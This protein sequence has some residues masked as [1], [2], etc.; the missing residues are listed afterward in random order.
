MSSSHSGE[1]KSSSGGTA[2]AFSVSSY[3][4]AVLANPLTVRATVLRK[5][6][7]FPVAAAEL[8][9]ENDILF[10]VLANPLHYPSTV[11][12][13][14]DDGN[15]VKSPS[16]RRGWTDPLA[17]HGVGSILSLPSTIGKH[18]VGEPF[19]AFLSFHNAATYA[20]G[21]V[22]FRIDCLHPTQQ[23]TSLVSYDCQRLEGKGNV[24][25]K[26]ELTLTDSGQHTL[27]VAV[28]FIDIVQEAKRLTWSSSFQVERAVTEVHRTLCAIPLLTRY[29]RNTANPLRTAGPTLEEV[30]SNIA[31]PTRKYALS[32]CLQNTSSLPLAIVDVALHAGDAFDVLPPPRRFAAKHIRPMPL[33][34]PVSSGEPKEAGDSFR[35]RYTGGGTDDVEDLHLHPGDRRSYVFEI[36]LKPD[37][38]RSLA[39]CHNAAGATVAVAPPNI[40]DL[41]HVEW[42]WR[43]ANGDGGTERSRPVR[44]SRIVKQPMLEL[45][46]VNVTPETPRAGMPMTLECVAVNYDSENHVDLALRV[47]PDHLVPALVY[48]GPLVCLLGLLEPCGTMKFCVSLVPWKSG[49]VAVRGGLELCDAREPSHLLWPLQPVTTQPPPLSSSVPLGPPSL[50]SSVVATELPEQLYPPVL[51]EVLVC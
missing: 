34:W 10:D 6:E 26:V 29:P 7:L 5:P 17:G 41:G 46:V 11:I 39:L 32:M 51:C 16:C 47:R 43:R 25:F 15:D 18:F 44:L 35:I 38:L 22:L 23:R 20:L 36:F 28:T 3:V 48:A 13:D 8:V 27:S 24:S 2:P 1:P 37:K 31:L 30:A 14:D 40:V 4:P 45:F 42:K 49:W 9:E 50:I 12:M 33:W 19:R 21:S